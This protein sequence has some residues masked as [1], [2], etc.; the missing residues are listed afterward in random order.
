MN[1][2]AGVA[3]SVGTFEL[4]FVKIGQTAQEFQA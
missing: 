3:S 2:G 4:S 1:Y